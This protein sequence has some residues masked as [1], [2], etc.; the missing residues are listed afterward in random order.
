MYDGS[1]IVNGIVDIFFFVQIP[2]GRNGKKSS[3]W[4]CLKR[5]LSSSASSFLKSSTDDKES[6]VCCPACQDKIIRVTVLDSESVRTKNELLVSLKHSSAA[7]KLKQKQKKVTIK[8][9]IGAQRH[10]NLEIP[11]LV[12]SLK[13]SNVELG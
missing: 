10:F 12:Q 2:A 4:S 1:D 11:V 9:L 8:H 13:S 7:R 5:S 3:L 6:K